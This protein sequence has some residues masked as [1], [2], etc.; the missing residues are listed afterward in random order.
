MTQPATREQFKEYC[1]RRLGAPVIEINV[2]D[3]Q[4][5]DRIDDALG[6][7]RD[8]HDDGTVRTFLKHQITDSDKTNGWIPIPT[9]V[10]YVNRLMPFSSQVI[11]SRNFF[12]VRYQIALNDLWDLNSGG[13]GGLEYYDQ[14]KQY[15]NLLDMKLNGLPDVEF[16]RRQNR[17]YVFGKFDDDFLVGDYLVVEALVA[18]DPETYN[19]VWQD[20]WLKAYTTELFRQQW[21]DNISKFDGVQLPGGI[22]ISGERLISQAERNIEKLIEDLENKYQSPIDFLVG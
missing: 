5:E 20:P 19:E 22:T 9:S 14:T 11:T 7:F 4:L 3:D 8:F 2:D 17:L 1:L 18:V 12:D 16:N 21:G 6:K 15:L 10:T 13:F